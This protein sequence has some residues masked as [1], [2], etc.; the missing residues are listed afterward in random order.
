MG[1]A[2]LA[3]L[4]LALQCGT[5]ATGR[6]SRRNRAR[7]HEPLHPP[8]PAHGKEVQL[9]F[10]GGGEKLGL[11]F[12]KGMLPPTVRHVK[13]GTWAAR[14]P[15]LKPGFALTTIGSTTLETRSYDDA[16]DLLKA[17][18]G[19]SSP[20]APLL[21]A[22]SDSGQPPPTQKP[23]DAQ[24]GVP[25]RVS[26]ACK[27]LRQRELEDTVRHLDAA[28]AKAKDKGAGWPPLAEALREA[29]M[30]D[31]EVAVFASSGQWGPAQQELQEQALARY[32]GVAGLAKELGGRASSPAVRAIEAAALGRAGGYSW[33][34]RRL[35]PAID[36][37]RRIIELGE[38]Q[39]GILSDEEL[40]EAHTQ[41]GIL[42]ITLGSVTD[43]RQHHLEA[44]QMLEAARKLAPLDP[45]P[46]AYLGFVFGQPQLADWASCSVSRSVAE[47]VPF[48]ELG[49]NLSDTCADRSTCWRG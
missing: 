23:P 40:A 5:P 12:V 47:M 14:Q 33:S 20:E 31:N 46:R 35:R 16:I 27:A 30:L 4:L 21:L 29:V 49:P 11:A 10:E 45:H 9:R 8:S 6:N 3:L 13:E 15:E 37:Q 24:A 32:E 28:L 44:V 42:L 1:R 26:A 17:A 36:A 41:L 19:A 7:H 43:E 39:A 25:R 22:F 38:E 18:C 48:R 2:A 34:M